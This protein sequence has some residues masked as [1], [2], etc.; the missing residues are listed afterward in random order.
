MLGSGKGCPKRPAP[1][2][3][4]AGSHLRSDYDPTPLGPSC[5]LTCKYA[6][7]SRFE[8]CVQRHVERVQKVS[9]L[10]PIGKEPVGSVF[11]CP[12]KAI[13]VPLSQQSDRQRA[14][15]RAEQEH[16]PLKS[17]CSS[18]RRPKDDI[19]SKPGFQIRARAAGIQCTLS[20]FTNK[21]PSCI[22]CWFALGSPL[23]GHRER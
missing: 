10:R 20:F 13:K 6:Y 12:V 17:S 3:E 23:L 15:R 18:A 7:S 9:S 11:L 4:A 19:L 2:T 8:G 5:F 1:P 16:A 14:P 21:R 22:A